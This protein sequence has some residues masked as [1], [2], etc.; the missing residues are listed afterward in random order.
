MMVDC[1]WLLRQA[2]VLC[3][4]NCASV[5]DGQAAEQASMVHATWMQQVGGGRPTTLM[6]EAAAVG[7]TQRRPHHHYYCCCCCCSW[8]SAALFTSTTDKGQCYNTNCNFITSYG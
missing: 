5:T 3:V 7:E 8:T 6:D 2:A 1:V 4:E